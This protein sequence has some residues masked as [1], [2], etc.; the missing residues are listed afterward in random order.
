MRPWSSARTNAIGKI[1]RLDREGQAPKDNPFVGKP[2]T[3]PEIFA[4]GLRN[5]EGIARSADGRLWVAD[6]GPKGGDELNELKAGANYGWPAATWGFDYSGEPM[7][8]AQSGPG[9]SDPILVWSP[10]HTPSDL[11]QYVGRTYP[12]WNGDLFTGGLS[13]GSVRRIRIKGDDVVLQE[14]LLAEMNERYRAVKVGPRQ[15]DLP[16]DRQPPGPPVAPAARRADA[17][18]DRQRRQALG[19]SRP[20]RPRSGYRWTRSTST[21]AATTSTTRPAAAPSSPRIAPAATASASSTPATSAR[22]STASW[23]AGRGRSPAT[24]T[25]PPSAIR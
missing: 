3:L 17:R 4:M 9:F 24:T 25:R 11:T 20:P 15:P 18:P 21:S 2:A 23:G 16:A 10:S 1:L 13:G 7:S 6:I 14:K 19:R 12:N 5:P 22:T 8:N